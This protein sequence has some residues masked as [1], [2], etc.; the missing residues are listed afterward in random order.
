MEFFDDLGFDVYK[1]MPDLP[2][3]TPS[4]PLTEGAHWAALP[5]L[6]ASPTGVLGAMA[7][8]VSLVRR[9]RPDAVILAT[10]FSPLALAVRWTGGVAGLRQVG[11]VAPQ[12]VRVGLAIVA[13]NVAETCAAC[14]AAGADGI[15]FATT[16]LGDGLLADDEY[17]MW[18]RP[19]DLRALDGCGA[20]WCNVL[21]MHADADLQWHRVADYPPPIFSWSDRKT[22]VTLAEVAH[23]LPNTTVMGGIDETGA[24][25]RGDA[26][27]LSAEMED[28]VRQTGGRRV[29]LAGGCSVPDD[30]PLAHLRL[31]RRIVRA[32]G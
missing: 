18:G 31:A 12:A 8:A 6:S 7:V 11:A 23:A 5:R 15:Y 10:V 21:H 4:V 16:G 29:I 24:V 32:W 28:A 22:G 17:Q 26:N 25:V 30:I 3:P 14:L 9:Q 19:F 1:V 27:G 13:D 20:G 2:Y